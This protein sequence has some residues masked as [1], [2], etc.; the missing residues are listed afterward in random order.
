MMG[1]GFV[2]GASA[3]NDA[4]RCERRAAFIAYITLGYPNAEATPALALALQTG[5]ADVIEL[6]VPFSDPVADGP[7]I[8]S[9]SQT[10]LRQGM[11]TVRCIATVK[12]CR[13]AGLTVPVLLMG[14]YNPILSYGIDA[15]VRDC[16]EAGVDGFIVPDLPPEEAGDL[17]AYC[18]ESGLALV[19]LVAPTTSLERAARIADRT[20]GFLYVV[21]RLGITGGDRAPDAAVAERIAQLKRLAKTP[22][23]VGFGVSTPGQAAPLAQVADA[24]IVGSAI[25]RRADEGAGALEAFVRSFVPA[26]A[27]NGETAALRG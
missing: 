11:T 16:S 23:A 24:I 27:R 7:A 13:A 20:S 3:I 6:G 17:E 19:Y 25:V 14:Y 12:E 5:G 9:A 1:R 4:L 18:R 10:A 22:V 8:Q 26:L 2:S 21:S 15:Y